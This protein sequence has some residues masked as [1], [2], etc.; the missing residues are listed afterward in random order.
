MICFYT[1]KKHFYVTALSITLCIELATESVKKGLSIDFRFIKNWFQEN[2]MVLNT[3]KR[4][5][6]CFRIGSENDDFI[7]D[8]IELANSYVI[9]W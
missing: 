5:Y 9:Y 8:R 3:M 1:Q 4:H 7:F 6:M 2:L